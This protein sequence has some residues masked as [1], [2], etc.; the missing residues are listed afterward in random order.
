[1][2]RDSNDFR[3]HSLNSLGELLP[4]ERECRRPDV[5]ETTAEQQLE[6]SPLLG[7]SYQALRAIRLLHCL[8]SASKAS[9]LSAKTA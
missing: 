7:P 6:T 1:M 5:A 2:Q 8:A 9:G 4:P 3:R